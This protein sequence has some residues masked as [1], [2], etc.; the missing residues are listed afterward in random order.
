MPGLFYKPV[1]QTC[2]GK[3]KPG[4]K[5]APGL[6]LGAKKES[7]TV[8]QLKAV[9]VAK[10]KSKEAGIELASKVHDTSPQ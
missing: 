2:F 9:V 7:Y 10:M 8:Q 5:L 6:K 4:L 3:Y 1:S